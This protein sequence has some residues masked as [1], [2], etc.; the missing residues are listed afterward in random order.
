MEEGAVIRRTKRETTED[1]KIVEIILAVVTNPWVAIQTA[2]G[3][4][5][6]MMA[7]KLRLCVNSR[8]SP[9]KAGGEKVP[10]KSKRRGLMFGEGVI[11]EENH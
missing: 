3:N 9:Q 11:L 1:G 5:I 7:T 6:S 4:T 8:I 2:T 10:P